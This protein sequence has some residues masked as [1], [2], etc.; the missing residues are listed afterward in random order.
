MVSRNLIV[1]Q[2]MVRVL[3]SRR[4]MDKRKLAREKNAISLVLYLISIFKGPMKTNGSVHKDVCLLLN[5]SKVLLSHSAGFA[6]AKVQ[7]SPFKR[8]LS[9]QLARF[10]SAPRTFFLFL[11]SL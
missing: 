6:A 9:M 4:T 1:N 8:S 7:R 10:E 3:I 11:S 5:Q 2:S